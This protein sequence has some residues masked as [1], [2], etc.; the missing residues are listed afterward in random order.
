MFFTEYEDR[1]IGLKPMNCPGHVQLFGTSAAPTATCRSAT[2]R[3]GLLH[4]HE[5]SGTLHGLLRVRHF[6]QDDAHIFCTEDQI[7]DEVTR[8]LD[9]GFDIYDSSASSRALELSTRP[10]NR[11]GD[12]AMWDQAEARARRRR[13]SD[14]GHRVRRST[15][16]RAPS[17][18]RRSTC[19]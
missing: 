7:Q 1:P 15:R 2:P 13:S 18:G 8:C 6:T 17:T 11:I 14:N 16:A 12:D 4:R 9:F 19:T 10:D 3:P 5:P